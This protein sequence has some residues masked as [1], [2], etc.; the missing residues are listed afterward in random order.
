M[1]IDK[2]ICGCDMLLKQ[3][4]MLM[5][6]FSFLNIH[7]VHLNLTL[8]ISTIIIKYEKQHIHYKEPVS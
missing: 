3:Y 2:Y 7:Y 4:Q 1:T 5:M 6:K 8:G